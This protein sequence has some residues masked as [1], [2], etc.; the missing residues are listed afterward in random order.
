MRPLKIY[1]ALQINNPTLQSKLQ[2]ATHWLWL[3][4]LWIVFYRFKYDINRVFIW[5][6]CSQSSVQLILCVVQTTLQNICLWYP[7]MGIKASNY[8]YLIAASFLS[9]KC[10]YLRKQRMQACWHQTWWQPSKQ[11]TWSYN[12]AISVDCLEVT[13]IILF[14][15][16]FQKASPAFF[17]NISLI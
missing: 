15:C 16:P 13:I 3:Q 12:S 10:D 6:I 17:A 1:V 5:R 2:I 9:W 7:W 4:T 14:Y 8:N 11:F